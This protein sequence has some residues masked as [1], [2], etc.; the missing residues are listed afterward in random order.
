MATLFDQIKALLALDIS[1][2]Q[3][4]ELLVFLSE[5]AQAGVIDPKPFV[6]F[7]VKAA[8]LSSEWNFMVAAGAGEFAEPKMF[9]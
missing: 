4:I 5:L 3:V 2:Y 7:C 8:S 1:N 6:K 9:S